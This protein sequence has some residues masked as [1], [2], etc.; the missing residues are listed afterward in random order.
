MANKNKGRFSFL[1]DLVEE[2]E[3]AINTE[4]Q[5]SNRKDYKSFLDRK[6]IPS[7]QTPNRNQ[8]QNPPANQRRYPG[9]GGQPYPGQ[10]P[11]TN[12][13]KYPGQGGQPYPGQNPPTNQGRYPGQGGQP[14]P[15][16]NPPYQQG[17][18][19]NSQQPN[20]RP[21]QRSKPIQES[22]ITDNEVSNNSYEDEDFYD[23][24]GYKNL[25]IEILGDSSLDSDVPTLAV[26]DEIK[27]DVKGKD[28]REKITKAIIW[29]EIL[30]PPKSRRK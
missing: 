30:Q 1:S 21:K 28:R 23:G 17:G 18:Q 29:S 24:F 19:G 4:L 11:P 22:P 25:E 10:N 14:Y 6:H 13:G 16:Q 8:W 20:Q 7:S 2:L 26:V 5:N 9:Q 12:Q 3:D 27:A 15:G